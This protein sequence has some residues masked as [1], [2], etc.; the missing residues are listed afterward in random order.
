MR[1]GGQ[2]DKSTEAMLA[3]MGDH[4]QKQKVSAIRNAIEE[5]VFTFNMFH[6]LYIY[7]STPKMK[8]VLRNFAFTRLYLKL[9]L[10]VGL[11]LFLIDSTSTLCNIH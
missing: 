8:L 6:H 9:N 1:E 11:F 4:L 10:G 2:M 5:A 7:I 3:Q